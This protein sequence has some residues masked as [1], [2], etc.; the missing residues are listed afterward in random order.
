MGFF[1]CYVQAYISS[2]T[3]NSIVKDIT[4][5]IGMSFYDMIVIVFILL[6]TVPWIFSVPLVKGIEIHFTICD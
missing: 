4:V 6:R 5:D 1:Q 3:K 2:Q